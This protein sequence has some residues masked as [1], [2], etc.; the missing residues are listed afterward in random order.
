MNCCWKDCDGE[1]EFEI[2]GI[3]FESDTYVCD[4]HLSES[5]SSDDTHTVRRMN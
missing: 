2:H 4:N 3:S 1:A 5:I